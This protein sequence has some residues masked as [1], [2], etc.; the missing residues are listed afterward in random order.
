MSQDLAEADLLHAV[1]NAWPAAVVLTD[2]DLCVVHCNQGA[3]ELL[4]YRAGDLPGRKLEV[5]LPPD[6]GPCEPI[7]R[8]KDGEAFLGQVCW[9]PVLDARGRL[10]GQLLTLEDLP[11]VSRF[12]AEL[13]E[14]SRRL[15]ESRESERLRL[16]R[17]LH[18]GA[19][20]ELIGIG[21]SL[22][23]VERS[24]GEVVPPL[25]LEPIRR[26]RGEVLR[27]ARL[28]RALVSE[29]RPAGLEEFGLLASIEGLVAKLMRDYAATGPRI[30]LELQDVQGLTESQQLCLFRAAQESLYNCL[31]HARAENVRMRL[32]RLEDRIVLSVSDDGCGFTPPRHLK[33]LARSDHYGLA[34]MAERVE[35]VGGTLAVESRPAQGTRVCVTLKLEGEEAP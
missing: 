33:E 20:Q 14:A 24:L 4:G 17:E 11:E 13:L 25:D 29:L 28:L 16:A 27:V 2:G 9:R 19:I 21:F 5:L 12:E 32:R 1:L 8:R 10:L 18:D 26:Q 7:L 30:Q 31:N 35:L 34:G 15:T 22:T 6:P 23:E 3:C